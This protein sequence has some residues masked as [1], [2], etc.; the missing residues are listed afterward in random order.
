MSVV[1]IIKSPLFL[2]FAGQCAQSYT[3]NEQSHLSHSALLQFKLL[4]YG[5]L[6]KHYS[7]AE[8]PPLLPQ[9][10]TDIYTTIIDLLGEK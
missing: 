7:H 4:L 10:M 9:Q 8:M 2:F 6:A 5:S 1:N 3:G